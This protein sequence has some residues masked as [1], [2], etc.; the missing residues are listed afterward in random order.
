MKLRRLSGPA[1]IRALE[2]L[3]FEVISQRGSHAK[4]RRVI[5]GKKQTLTVP[6]HRQLDAGTLVAIFRQA[7]R[8][9]P[10]DEL[11]PHFYTD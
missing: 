4:L 5:H 6:T 10:E 11:H 1:V 3:G 7:Q 8:Y 9:V 2:Q